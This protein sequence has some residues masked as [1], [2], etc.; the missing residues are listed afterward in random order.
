V[1]AIIDEAERTLGDKEFATRVG[2]SLEESASI[3]F[4]IESTLGRIP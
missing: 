2:F 3:R 4:Q 1:L